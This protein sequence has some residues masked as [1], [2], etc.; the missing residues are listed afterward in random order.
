MTPVLVMVLD[1]TP[2]AKAIKMKIEKWE[3][4]PGSPVVET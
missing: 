1:M 2:K 4:F 3:D